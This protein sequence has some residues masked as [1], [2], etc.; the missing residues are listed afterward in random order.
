MLLT[1]YQQ[2]SVMYSSGS[3]PPPRTTPTSEPQLP[4]NE[5]NTLKVPFGTRSAQP[6]SKSAL[7]TRSA[8]SNLSEYTTLESSK[9]NKRTSFGK[10][11]RTADKSDFVKAVR[12]GFLGAL[13]ASAVAVTAPL[14]FVAVPIIILA[15]STLAIPVA[16]VVGVVGLAILLSKEETNFKKLNAVLSE[17]NEAARSAEESDGFIVK[18][19]SIYGDRAEEMKQLMEIGDK[20]PEE[21]KNNFNH[22]VG[23][24]QMEIFRLVNNYD[25]EDYPKEAIK[26]TDSLINEL[27]NF[28]RAN[29]I[30]F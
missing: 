9:P 8:K 16:G 1:V 19:K 14:T 29:N 21:L 23:D 13:T 17:H 2:E 12:L 18:S 11:L 20:L 27:Q 26:L 24:K 22:L 10:M 25:F 4:L 6:I 5:V 3:T 28:F 7:P 15:A 30:Q